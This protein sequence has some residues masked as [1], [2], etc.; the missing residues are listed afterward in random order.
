MSRLGTGRVSVAVRDYA[1]LVGELFPTVND[2]SEPYDT[3]IGLP[4]VQAVSEFF[5][6][7][8][9]CPRYFNPVTHSVSIGS[10][11]P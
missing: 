5:D 10:A 4:F 6:I 9:N 7:F 1:G 8:A 3:C 2:E 11:S